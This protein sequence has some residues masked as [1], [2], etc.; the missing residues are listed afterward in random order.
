MAK[1]SHEQVEVIGQ[2]NTTISE[3]AEISKQTAELMEQNTSASESLEQIS[4]TLKQ[5]IAHFKI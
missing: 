1:A 2:V 5:H 3:M 4:A